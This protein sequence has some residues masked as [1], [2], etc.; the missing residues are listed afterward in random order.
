MIR[1]TAILLF[2]LTVTAFCVE[3]HNA[4]RTNLVP[5]G[6]FDENPKTLTGWDALPADGTVKWLP[7]D[8]EKHGKVIGFAMSQKI[9]ESTGVLFYSV[10]IPVKDG[11]NY[12]F[13][14]DYKSLG[15]MPK[16]FVKGYGLFPDANGKVEARELYKKQIFEK[17]AST[18]WKTLT[19]EFTP[20]NPLYKGKIEIKWVKVLLYAYLKPGEIFFDNVK[21]EEM[22]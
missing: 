4:K 19:M 9:A 14:L 20:H 1:L 22:E 11:R 13:S 10:F 21:I 5:N 8:D 6:T 15:P 12:R 3:P 18:E 2:F 17:A 16:P 7:L